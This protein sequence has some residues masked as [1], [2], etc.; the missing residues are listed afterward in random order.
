[1]AKPGPKPKPT[2]LHK[3]HGTLNVTRYRDR[4]KEPDA[5]A[6]DLS[7]PPEFLTASQKESWRYA[8]A[9]APLNVLRMI[10][11]EVLRVWVE[12]EDRHRQAMIQQA[13]IDA[14]NPVKLLTRTKAG[15]LRASPY[16]RIINSAAELMLR[17]GE[18]LGFSPASRPRLAGGGGGGAAAEPEPDSPWTRLKVLQGGAA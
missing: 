11:R 10:D 5:P 12:A 8:I 14:T 2:A 7:E 3:L 17:S 18:Q 13:K 1:M 16:L 9:H 4:A 6:G 15:E